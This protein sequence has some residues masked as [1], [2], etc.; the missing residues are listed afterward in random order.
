MTQITLEQHLLVKK[1]NS[2]E[3]K[4]LVPDADKM[5]VMTFVYFQLLEVSTILDDRQKNY[6]ESINSCI[7]AQTR[8]NAAL[9][10]KNFKM[11]LTLEEKENEV[12]AQLLADPGTYALQR[13]FGV[14]LRKVAN[15]QAVKLLADQEKDIDR[16]NQKMVF[17]RD[18][19]LQFGTAINQRM[20]LTTS[21]TQTVGNS[22]AQTQGVASSIANTMRELSNKIMGG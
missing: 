18:N 16:S 12:L 15:S 2:D 22:S 6:M 11:P 13:D 19:L 3:S 14:D 4:E 20:S 21:E 1:V 8:N 5:N 9:E 17:E 7:D 10:E